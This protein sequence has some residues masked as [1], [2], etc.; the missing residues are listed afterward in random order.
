[1]MRAM[2]YAWQDQPIRTTLP[3]FQKH[4]KELDKVVVAS[5]K[6]LEKN[7]DDLEGLFF[8]MSVH[9][10][11]AEYYARE[12]S[13]IKAV[14]QAQKTYS[15][16]KFTMEQTSKSP[17]FYFLAGLYNYFREK[18]PERHSV[19][20]PFLW[21]YRSGDMERGL[22]QLDSA[23]NY[24]KIVKVEAGLYLSYIY[25][26]YELKPEIALN[27]LKKLHKE[28][29]SNSYFKTKYIECLVLETYFEEALPL[30]QEMIDHEKPYYQLCGLTYQALY[31]EK[32]LNSASQAEKYYNMAIQTGE[33]NPDRGEYYKSLTY[34]GMGRLLVAKGEFVAASK[35]LNQAIELDESPKVTAEAKLRLENI[36][37]Q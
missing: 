14:G 28:Y 27:Y 21:F 9:G 19:Y 17:E 4:L 26:R 8:E 16:L 13:Y 25:L 15:M 7:P 11:K 36:E 30:I 33:K 35:Y 37:N 6:L 29:P 12:G 20:K 31:F 3:I 22:I 5:Q 10:L 24:S 2:N 1:M 32:V 23:V 18:Y 34:L